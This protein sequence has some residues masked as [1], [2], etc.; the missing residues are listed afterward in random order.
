MSGPSV[1]LVGL[2]VGTNAIKAVEVRRVKGRAVVAGWSQIPTPPGAVSEGG[3]ADPC[4]VAEA[5]GRLFGGAL[6]RRPVVV[7]AGGSGVLFRTIHLPRM[8][9]REL[10]EVLKWESEKHLPLEREESVVDFAILDGETL[11]RQMPV[12]L[13][14]THRRVVEGYLGALRLARLAVRA[15][16]AD[17]LANFRALRLFPHYTGSGALA[18]LD[19]GGATSKLAVYLEGA[20][21][22]VRTLPFGGRDLAEA[23]RRGEACDPARA[24]ELKVLHGLSPG[25][26]VAGWLRAAL[27]D[28]IAECRRTLDFFLNSNRG[29]P[30][31][32]MA[33]L[34]GEWRTPGLAEEFEAS[35]LRAMED[36]LEGVRAWVADPTDLLGPGGPLASVGWAAQALNRGGQRLGPQFLGA[37]GLGL[38]GV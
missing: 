20:P 7:A 1:P 11:D 36:R 29:V 26:P 21:R 2:D 25:S 27:E 16:D 23:V 5:L 15:V 32:A 13:V 4:A 12:L 38:R 9:P 22:L 24:E 35:L 10:A 33:L 37:L 31:T 28:I 30:I 6:R 8:T 19:L 14:G 3:V 17:A 18:A 34:G